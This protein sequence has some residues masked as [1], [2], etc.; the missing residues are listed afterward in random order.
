M[1]ITANALGPFDT[2]FQPAAVTAFTKAFFSPT[3]NVVGLATITAARSGAPDLFSAQ[4]SALAAPYIF[5][6]GDE[7]LPIG[8]YTGT[9]PEP[10][11]DAI[12]RLVAT[13][14]FHL[15]LAGPSDTD[16]RIAWIARHCRDLGRPSGAGVVPGASPV[17]AYYCTPRDAAG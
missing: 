15:V 11:V 2:P 9:I 12:R 5:A 14:A 1:W 17:L 7:V 13:G 6:T 8:G 16:P 10:T 4:T 3:R